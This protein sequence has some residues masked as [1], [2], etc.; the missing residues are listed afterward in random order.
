MKMNAKSLIGIAAPAIVVLAWRIAGG[1]V[2][3]ASESR[4]D[5]ARST[6]LAGQ[7]TSIGPSPLAAQSNANNLQSGR[8]A[9]I[10]VDP[11]DSSHW[12]IGTGGGVW[13]TRTS[14]QAWAPI[15]DDAPTTAIGAVAFAP[16]DT[17]VI[18]VGTGEAMNAGFA[19]VG[20]GIL[21]SING[22]QTWALRGESSFARASIK[23]IRVDP[24]DANVVV[25]ASSRGGFGRDAREAAFTSPPPFGVHRSSDGGSTWTRTLIGQITALEVDGS[26]YSRQ[27]AAVGDQRIGVHRD[28]PGALPNGLYRSVDGG[29]SWTPVQGPWGTDAAPTTRSN[30]GRIE[31]AMAPSNPNVVYASMQ[32]P[33]NGGSNATGLMGL[34]KTENAWA[35]QPSW[36]EISTEATGAGGYCGPS[37]CGYSHAVSID[38][39]DPTTFFGGT[40]EQGFWRCAGCGSM[41]SWSERVLKS[42]VHP[43]FHAIAWA[44]NRLIV[45]TDGGVWSSTDQGAT[46]QNHNRGLSTNMFFSGGLHPTDA[47][48]VLGGLRDFALSVHRA[49]TG[50][51][52]LQQAS[53][54]EWGEAEVAVSSSH[55]DT[56][57]MAAWLRGTIQRT[58]DGGRTSQ[59]V[60]EGIDATGIA[61]VAPVRK[62][63][64]NDDVF[65]TGT[66]RMWRTENFFSA[67]VPTWSPNGPAHPFQFPNSLAAPG[68]IFSIAYLDDRTCGSYAYGNRGGEVRLTR[69][70]GAT[71]MNLDPSKSLPARPIT[72]LAFDPSNSNRLFAVLSSYDEE[73]PGK[74]GHIFRTDNATAAS[75]TWTLLGPPATPFANAPFNVVAV[76]PRDPQL[77]YAGSDNGLWRSFDGGTTWARDGLESGLPA[78]PVFDVQIN[79]TRTV[80]FTYGRGAYELVR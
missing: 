43:D 54:S 18:Y 46:W 60:N 39:I 73:T 42:G 22:G 58:T 53:T 30:V 57:W 77:I 45:G 17:S 2:D 14:G 9:S 55:P 41:P 62:C 65:V 7:W 78:V 13:E 36:I 25:A 38:P 44:G 51:K 59:L 52:I 8:V 70:G 50:W 21:K 32:V 5:V 64:F 49:A 71:W 63:P 23:R 74:S 37:K 31:L 79:A 10:A 29:V 11:R 15:T 48:F 35:E 20:V 28:T 76:D 67:P 61:F 6:A 80:I 4:R 68:T 3:V 72:G 56:D 1:A 26:N 16:S 69:D 24:A 33:P 75:P 47:T 40:A 66:N 27:Y 12:L 34:F 19:H